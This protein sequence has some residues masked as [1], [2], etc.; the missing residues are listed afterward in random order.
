[1]KCLA[2]SML[3]CPGASIPISQWCIL[4]I[5]PYFHKKFNFPQFSFN[6]RFLLS[7]ILTIMHSYFTR[8]G[9]PWTRESILRFHL[10]F[11]TVLSV[12]YYSI[13]MVIMSKCF[14]LWSLCPESVSV[15]YK[16][17]SSPRYVS[18]QHVTVSV[19]LNYL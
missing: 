17:F 11:M 5:P 16:C 13:K 7:P 10:R 4:Y 3:T 1:M 19:E 18:F 2:Q 12:V 9:R 6:L 8:T 15:S 14:F